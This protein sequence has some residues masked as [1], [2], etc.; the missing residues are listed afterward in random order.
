MNNYSEKFKKMRV[1]GKLA[2]QCLD[3]ITDHIKPGI[4]TQKIHNLCF[5]YITYNGG[6]SPPLF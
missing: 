2:A 6:Y 1:A 3:M 5:Q 4:S